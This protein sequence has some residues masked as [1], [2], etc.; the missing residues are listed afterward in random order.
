MSTASQN[1]NTLQQESS[2]GTTHR[3]WIS[4]TGT[5]PQ[6]HTTHSHDF[7]SKWIVIQCNGGQSVA[8]TGEISFV[9]LIKVGFVLHL[10]QTSKH[11]YI[12]NKIS[13]E[14]L[15]EYNSNCN[16]LHPRSLARGNSRR[17]LITYLTISKKTFNRF[18]GPR[19]QEGFQ[20]HFEGVLAI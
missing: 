13:V 3:R 5:T 6:I 20:N 11:P 10:L 19:R 12:Q 14:D 7:A 16:Q 4:S 8:L 15:S 1:T 9:Q 18:L 2:S 17:F